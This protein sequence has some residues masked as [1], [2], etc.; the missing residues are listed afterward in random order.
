[1]KI[2][3]HKELLS[4]YKINTPLRLAAFLAQVDHESQG[5]TRTLEN[6]NYS[7][8]ALTA[9]WPKRFPP[10]IALQY[11]RQPERIAN[12]AYADRMGNGAESSGDGWRYRGRGYIQLTGRD[13]YMDFSRNKRMP[14]EEV[15]AY[16]E[17]E[18]G[19]MESAA[20]WYSSRNLNALADKGDIKGM[21]KV[22]NGGYNG[23]AD[24]VAL[25]DK[26]KTEVA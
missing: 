15:A 7:A 11:H 9:T 6:L 25:Y 5:F 24:R 13:N 19:A 18:Q 10:E 16:L 2:K 17:T 26:Y 23:L 12:R 22:I 8:T 1:M 3:G 21:T 4:T 20:W 14:L